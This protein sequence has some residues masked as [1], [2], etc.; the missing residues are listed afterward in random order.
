MRWLCRFVSSTVLI[1]LLVT[2][3][4][5][6]RAQE[7]SEDNGP[8]EASDNAADETG[9]SPVSFSND[10]APILAQKCLACH[11][12]QDPQGEYQLYNYE[13]LV[14]PGYSESPV[15]APG[16]PDE[17]QLYL[18]ITEEDEDLRMPM[19]GDPLA[20]E[21]I[22]LIRRWIEQG[23]AFDGADPTVALPSLLPRS[24]HPAPPEAYRVTVPIAALA[25]RPDGGELAVG[26]YHEVTIWNP[27][28]GALVRR[29]SN[30]AERV[31]GL[32]YS[33]DGAVLAVASG[34]PGQS[35]E[36][37]LFDPASGELVRSLATMADVAF[38]VTFRPDGAK[39]AAAGADRAIRIFDVA[40]GE[41][42]VLIEDHADWVMAIAWS[43]D[44]ARLVS[45]S[46]DKT[47]K[48]FD[49]TNGEA[50]A[51]FPAHGEAV[52]AAAFN[53]DG[54]Q[55]FTAGGDKRIRVWNPADAKQIAE[56]GGFGHEV[57]GL[58]LTAGKL[59]SCSA[60]KTV[61]QHETEK[62]EQVRVYAGH[63]DWVYAIA[64]H[65]PTGRLASGGFDGEVRIWNV[66][67]GEPVLTFLAAPGYLPADQ[68]AAAQ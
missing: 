24:R 12:Q 9:P 47:S 66:E 48:V 27:A 23:A 61:R 22:A 13:H 67:D 64:C 63:G 59:F 42:D 11:G 35:G 26:G 55:V 46:R 6:L 38:D 4:S 10:I 58:V 40:S 56:I 31:Y 2:L 41:R 16:K 33:P 3:A 18:L 45:A 50:Q 51:T 29:I 14:Q 65:E 37:S 60:D 30:V 36:V 43:H 7:A 44:G 54:T 21:E 25:F 53:A 17:S 28:D 49:A 20:A 57:F 39:L 62:R 34:T 5:P 52:Y 19:E 8:A 15:I 32:D 1:A 68:Q